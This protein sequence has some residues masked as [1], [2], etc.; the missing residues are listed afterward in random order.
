MSTTKTPEALLARLRRG[1]RFVITS[2]TSPDGDSVGSSLGLARLLRGLGKAAWVWFRDPLPPV[3]ASLPGAD[4]VHVGTAVPAGFPADFDAAI[5]LECPSLER[6]GLESSLAELPVLNID[7][8]LG[9]R[10]YGE[11]NWVDSAAPAV[12]EMVYR[13]TTELH[14]TWD[15]D[16]ADLLYLALA[17]DTGGFRFSNTTLAAFEAAAAMMRA[18]ASPERVT[19]WLYESQPVSAVRLLG[20]MLP[21]LELHAAGSIATVV[22]TR[23]MFARAGAAPGDSEGLIDHPRSIAGVAATA[24]FKELGDGRWKISLRSRGSLDVERIAQGFGGGGHRNAA[25]CTLDGPLPA[26]QE[27]IIAALVAA[28]EADES[29]G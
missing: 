13:L 3:F 18:G 20:E 16:S 15:R 6:T 17:S 25:G 29:H 1:R 22:L 21:S 9:N 11:V 7:H 26:V 2:H 8:H 12:G 4:R 28:R 19:T 23:E 5:V 10:L 24:L 27:R 14:V